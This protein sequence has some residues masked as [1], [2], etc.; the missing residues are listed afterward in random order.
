M[1]QAYLDDVVLKPGENTLPLTATVDAIAIF[2]AFLASNNTS[3]GGV[4]PFVISGNS[5][6]YNGQH[7]PYFTEALRAN[8]FTVH[9]N[10]SQ[11]LQSLDI[12]I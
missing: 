10:V 8:N 9:L 7:L 3:Q 4:M 2:N 11:A 12:R 1:G 5:S 6:V